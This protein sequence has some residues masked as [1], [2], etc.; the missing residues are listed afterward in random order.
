MNKKDVSERDICTKYVTPVLKM[1]VGRFIR[2][3]DLNWQP[4]L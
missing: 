2:K 3:F 1:R 4:E